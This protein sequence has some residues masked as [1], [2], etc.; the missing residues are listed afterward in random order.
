MGGRKGGKKEGRMEGGKAGGK[1]V[2][3]RLLEQN[4]LPVSDQTTSIGVNLTTHF[5]KHSVSKSCHFCPRIQPGMKDSKETK[6]KHHSTWQHAA[7][8][9]Q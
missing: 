7:E 8:C 6:N 3:S 1:E 5:V 9:R 2:F 4:V